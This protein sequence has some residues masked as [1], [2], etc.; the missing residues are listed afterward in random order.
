MHFEQFHEFIEKLYLRQF[1][2]ERDNLKRKLLSTNFKLKKANTE[3]EKEDLLKE[4]A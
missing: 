3:E 1:D 4:K 2:T